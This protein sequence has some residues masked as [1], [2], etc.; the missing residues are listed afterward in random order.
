MFGLDWRLTRTMPHTLEHLELEAKKK[1]LQDAQEES[2]S[3]RESLIN[4]NA[5]TGD[6]RNSL[7]DI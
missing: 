4:E 2:I 7:D 1:A 5:I 6:K 3:V